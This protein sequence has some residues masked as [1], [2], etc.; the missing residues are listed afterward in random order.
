MTAAGR[1]WLQIGKRRTKGRRLGQLCQGFEHLLQLVGRDDFSFRHAGQF[2]EHFGSGRF[3][4][5]FDRFALH[6]E[7]RFE[8][9]PR[10]LTGEIDLMLARFFRSDSGPLNMPHSSPLDDRRTVSEGPEGAVMPR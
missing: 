10:F 9:C 4:G 7:R 1:G 6:E 8:A 5:A 2:L 3:A